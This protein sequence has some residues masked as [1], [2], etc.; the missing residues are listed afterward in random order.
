MVK[1]VHLKKLDPSQCLIDPSLKWIYASV[2]TNRGNNATM[3]PWCWKSFP[4]N[5]SLKGK[6]PKIKS[7]LIPPTFGFSHSSSLSHKG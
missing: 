7:G 3:M 1:N 2:L 4:M 5:L 6:L